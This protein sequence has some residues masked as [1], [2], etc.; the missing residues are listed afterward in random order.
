[1]RRAIPAYL[2]AGDER[3]ESMWAGC[4]L[5]FSLRCALARNLTNFPKYQD[6]ESARG[7]YRV[8]R[9][10]IDAVGNANAP[11]RLHFLADGRRAKGFR[12]LSLIGDLSEAPFPLK[13]SG[14]SRTWISSKLVHRPQLLTYTA[15]SETIG[16]IPQPTQEVAIEVF[17]DMARVE[18]VAPHI[19]PMSFLTIPLIRGFRESRYA[20]TLGIHGAIERGAY[21][22]SITALS[23]CSCASISALLSM[24]IFLGHGPIGGL[25]A[26]LSQVEVLLSTAPM[27]GSTYSTAYRT[28]LT[29]FL[30]D[31]ARAASDRLR[32][33]PLG[34]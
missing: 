14:V 9:N 16:A 10:I 26:Q 12:A 17:G 28:E 21:R 8:G 18:D 19:S 25:S 1:M 34:G 32:I 11:N 31:A 20:L 4:T 6:L 15:S 33:L 22:E 24:R 3:G 5:T 30:S 2:H 13:Q 23:R 7:L 29:R 27:G